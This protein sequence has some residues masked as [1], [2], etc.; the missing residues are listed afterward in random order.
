MKSVKDLEARLRSIRG[1]S[2]QLD[3]A[4]A[5]LTAR[6]AKIDAHVIQTEEYDDAPELTDEEL[7]RAVVKTP[8]EPSK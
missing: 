7:A 3:K 2:E 8:D 6:L 5:E 4:Q 1:M